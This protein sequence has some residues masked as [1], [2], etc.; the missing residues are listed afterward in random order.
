VLK[1]WFLGQKIL[2]PDFSGVTVIGN[3]EKLNNASFDFIF[4]K[5]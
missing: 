4:K 5:N 1:N 3:W 2:N